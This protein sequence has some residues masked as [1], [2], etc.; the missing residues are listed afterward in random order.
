MVA[1]RSFVPIRTCRASR[2]FEPRAADA[3]RRVFEVLVNPDNDGKPEAAKAALA[4]MAPRTWRKHRTQEL[5]TEALA[6]RR[7]AYV[8][9]LPAIDAALLKM[10]LKGSLPHILVFYERVEGWRPGLRIEKRY[11]DADM[12]VWRSLTDEDKRIIGD[13]MT[14]RLRERTRSCLQVSAE[15][16]QG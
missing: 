14:K 13:M 11:Q 1:V 10:A 6:A 3:Q 9:Y 8:R 12:E 15:P 2:R 7:A 4:G 16:E 5:T